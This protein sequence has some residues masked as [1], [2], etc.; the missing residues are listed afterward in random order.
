MTT[1]AHLLPVLQEG[2]LETDIERL[3]LE[4]GRLEEAGDFAGAA[5][6]FTRAIELDP[7]N[8]AAHHRRGW[9]RAHLGD[10]KGELADW[11]KAIEIGRAHV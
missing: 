4:G 6:T 11:S 2:A 7:L 10:L 5:E 3:L 8:A 1:H 9:A